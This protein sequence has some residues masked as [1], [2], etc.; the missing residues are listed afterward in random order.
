M[1]AKGRTTQRGYGSAHQRRRRREARRVKAG[2]ATCWRC[3]E[4]IHPDEPWDLGHDDK[5]RS[6]Y[7]GPEHR[8]CNRA[9]ASHRPPRKRPKKQHP[10]LLRASLSLLGGGEGPKNGS[11]IRDR[12][13]SGSHSVRVN[14][15]PFPRCC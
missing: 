4:K 7:R 1:A 5:D 8:R 13:D 3:Q 10:G 14:G 11:E 6:L 15:F 9:V 12:G 2:T